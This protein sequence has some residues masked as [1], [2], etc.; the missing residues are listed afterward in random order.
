MLVLYI[1]IYNIYIYICTSCRFAPVAQ[2]HLLID[3]PLLPLL[4]PSLPLS[5]PL[6]QGLRNV[7]H[8]KLLYDGLRRKEFLNLCWVKDAGRWRG[9]GVGVRLE[10]RR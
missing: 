3:L 9:R 6:P 10:R 1:Y 5:F 7:V 8:R 2:P 4:F